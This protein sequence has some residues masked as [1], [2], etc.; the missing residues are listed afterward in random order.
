MKAAT[1]TSDSTPESSAQEPSI[2]WLR[3]KVADLVGLDIESPIRG[4]ASANAGVLSDL[5]REAITKNASGQ[6]DPDTA[7]NRVFA[8]V[9]AVTGMHFKPQERNEP[10]GPMVAWGDGRRSAIP[11]D[12]RGPPVDILN[13]VADRA[14]HPVLR[15]RV[16]DVVWLL[17]RKRSGLGVSAVVAY[18][19]IIKKVDR[20]ELTFRFDE[21]AEKKKGALRHD[22]RNLL[23]RALQIGRVIGW[24]KPETVAARDL[25]SDLR[26]RA[27]QNHAIGAVL[28]FSALDLDFGVSDAASVGQDIEV[29]LATLPSETDPHTIVNLWKLTARAYHLAKREGDVHRCQ[30]QA[31]EQLVVMADHQN[32][33]AMM[34]SHLLAEAIA[35]L[36]GVP[37][38][39]ERRKELRH[40]IIDVQAGISEEM[41][42]FRHPLDLGDLIKQV[43]ERVA[44]RRLR[45]QLF[46]LAALTD[47][48][49]PAELSHEAAK[50]IQAHPLSSLFGASHHD[51][52]GKVIHRSAGGGFGQGDDD[53]IQRQIAQAE[54]LRRKVAASGGIEVALHVIAQEHFLSDD[55]FQALL[56][57]S[58]FV[59]PDL[60]R[61]FSRGFI[62]FFQGDYVSALYILTPLLENSLRYVLKSHGHDV[63]IFDDAT[64]TQED[65]TISVLFEQMRNEL[66]V[67]FGAA[68]TAD[69]ENVFL[70]KVGPHLRHALSH[71]L[72]HD[73]TPH[74]DDA[75]YAC[76]LIFHLCL[77]PLFEYRTQLE[78]PY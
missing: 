52:E 45:D 69:I 53:A 2:P 62:R 40:R 29:T 75:I 26:T 51:H 47:S 71:G 24:D 60:R 50:S 73:G 28:L 7:A 15:A 16:A 25:A 35:E 9:S 65:R 55:T 5:Y 77:L 12:F 46:A 21:D 17:D 37:G 1:S 4:S 39:K 33:S 8:M 58:P 70:K 49:D 31:A 43:E 42:I 56:A 41:S 63:T 78:L 23:R 68:I 36:H 20:G 19:A 74:G 67:V 18:V 13:A 10:F 61:T 3:A 64:Q 14:T 34:A 59:P 76:W 11:S 27:V 57:Y 48:P 44:G 38:K 32:H 54:S 6:P 30:A 22:A 72:L 66:D